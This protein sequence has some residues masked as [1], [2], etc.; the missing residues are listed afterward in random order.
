M[1]TYSY[2]EGKNIIYKSDYYSILLQRNVNDAPGYL[3]KKIS[4]DSVIDNVLES[5]C[6]VCD[7]SVL[8]DMLWEILHIMVIIL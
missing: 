6:L 3:L 1:P 2:E 5:E 7:N 8:T 4:D